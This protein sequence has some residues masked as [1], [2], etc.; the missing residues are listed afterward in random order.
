MDQ[1]IPLR[2]LEEFSI[3]S[4]SSE[5]GSIMQN[6]SVD[7]APTPS[8]SSSSSSSSS[9]LRKT[10][11]GLPRELRDYI[12]EFVYDEDL[13]VV[14]GRR[15]ILPVG[16][17]GPSHPDS[18]SQI[19]S[20]HRVIYPGSHPSFGAKIVDSH[21]DPDSEPEQAEMTA[22]GAAVRKSLRAYGDPASSN[23]VNDEPAALE[24]TTRKNWLSSIPLASCCGARCTKRSSRHDSPPAISTDQ[25]A[26][27]E[28][29]EV[30]DEAVVIN[31]FVSNTCLTG[32]LL[33][34]KQNYNEAAKYLY[35][36]CTFH[37]EDFELTTKFIR[38]VRSDTL[39]H[40]NRIAVYYP[41]EAEGSLKAIQAIGDHPDLGSFYEQSNVFL[42]DAESRLRRALVSFDADPTDDHALAYNIATQGTTFYQSLD[43]PNRPVCVPSSLFPPRWL[44]GVMCRLLVVS[45]KGAN[46]LTIWI[47]DTPE[48]E[49]NAH[50]DEVYEAALLQFAAMGDV[51][52]VS[53]KKWGDPSDNSGDEDARWHE[54]NWMKMRTLNGVEE[55]I[56]RGE[57]GALDRHAM[58]MPDPDDDD[59]A[60]DDADE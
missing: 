28:A 29:T 48:L 43:D 55:M 26:D 39:E 32:I 51:D 2:V 57:H 23:K 54:V 16:S 20:R 17:E 22:Y 21:V 49:F 13:Y 47:G 41:E 46:D 7:M 11:N 19:T 30:N 3:P 36:S 52:A 14:L 33:V 4:P 60:D 12:Y 8:V 35:R 24:T 50:R 38:A 59:D 6:G 58:V 5:T 1:E 9:L 42:P 25:E 15:G 44:F 27:N 40:I 37:F 53:V 18:T 31:S 56:R 10:F 34:S 45:M